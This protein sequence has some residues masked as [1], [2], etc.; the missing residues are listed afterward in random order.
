[1]ESSKSLKGH[2]D[3]CTAELQQERHESALLRKELQALHGDKC[4]KDA[5]KD[6]L[7]GLCLSVTDRLGTQENKLSEAI[8]NTDREI[9]NRLSD[10]LRLLESAGGKPPQS[11]KEVLEM[12]G[13]IETLST[14][15]GDRLQSADD[16]SEALRNAGT[17]VMEALKSRVETL[18]EIQ[19]TKNELEERI[20]SLQV[21][22]ARLE[23]AARG[24]EERIPELRTQLAAK[25]SELDRY[26]AESNVKSERNR[27]RLNDMKK[28][29]EQCREELA[30]KDNELRQ[31]ESKIE[32][33]SIAQQELEILQ[34]TQAKSASELADVTKQFR[35][36]QMAL[37]EQ[38]EL[39]RTMQVRNTDLEERLSSAEQKARDVEREMLRFKATASDDLK[40]QRIEAETDRRKSLESEKRSY[41]QKVSN[42]Q[43]LR[44]EA[45][46]MVE[47]LKEESK[48]CKEDMENKEQLIIALEEEK[49]ILQDTSEEQAERLAQ[50]EQGSI[51]QSA[52]YH[53]L[54][55]T[56]KSAAS[57]ISQLKTKLEEN[58]EEAATKNRLFNDINENVEV[59]IHQYVAVMSRLE[60]YERIE[61]KVQ[62]YCRKRG[63]SFEAS[64]MDA[65]LEILAEFENRK[66]N[67]RN[68]KTVSHDAGTQT[69]SFTSKLM[70]L[71]DPKSPEILDSQAPCAPSSS[72]LPRRGIRSIAP[73]R[74]A[75]FA[76]APLFAR[77]SSEEITGKFTTWTTQ[78]PEDARRHPLLQSPE[79][80][81]SQDKGGVFTR[82]PSCSPLSMLNSSEVGEND[83]CYILPLDRLG[84]KE[85][86]RE[87]NP[88]ERYPTTA[89]T[90]A[91]VKPSK[92]QADKPGPKL[93]AKKPLKS[94]LKQTTPRNNL[95]DDKATLS[96]DIAKTPLSDATSMK[97][98]T[99]RLPS[100]ARLATL[101]GVHDPSK[102]VPYNTRTR[103]GSTPRSESKQSITP[104]QS[105]SSVSQLN[106][107]KRS[108]SLLSSG[109]TS[110]PPTK[111]AR[112]SL[113]GR[114]FQAVSS[115]VP[116]AIRKGEG[117]VV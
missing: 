44:A 64:A 3:R 47:G 76:N 16:G 27:S 83:D 102:K 100:K 69:T 101:S 55:E 8:S 117:S 99:G 28:E 50:L 22:N 110:E 10:C 33:G 2:L 60:S 111:Q 109:V 54:A 36:C 104:V 4:L 43:R 6:L 29:L 98:P 20:S 71:Q 85:G 14:S 95:M 17:E 57:D 93:I 72:P 91:G 81:D 67:V 103:S 68:K 66:D 41:V 112:L 59:V 80:E 19:D 62:D 92:A 75:I 9:Q 74:S 46:A 115:F 21:A 25:E 24:H 42:L 35:D 51:S 37:A 63:I 106:F 52:E 18:F 1:M 53:S 108:M 113:P 105:E 26:R 97:P 23:A 87:E 116:E 107:R 86:Q 89:P 12:M 38:S 11:P 84:N 79:V 61:T 32:A 34:A 96:S 94:C 82:S 70:R 56:L 78:D 30:T 39:V 40:R 88:S 90:K 49:A 73:Q 48:R 15:I 77:G 65:I 114:E 31:A 13:L 45:E 58:E 5:I 7:D